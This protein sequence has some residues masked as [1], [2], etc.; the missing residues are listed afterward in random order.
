VMFGKG[1]M[2]VDEFTS[3]NQLADYIR[4]CE[5]K[6]TDRFASG[7]F[8]GVIL[9]IIVSILTRIWWLQ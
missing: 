9:G 5:R 1:K 4:A 2:L 3:V 6:A 7:L 8:W